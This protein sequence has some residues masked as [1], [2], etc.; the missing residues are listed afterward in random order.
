MVFVPIQG[1][2]FGTIRIC[3]RFFT[4]SRRTIT[5]LASP[6]PLLSSALELALPSSPP[7]VR[8]RSDGRVRPPSAHPRPGLP[9]RCRRQ[10]SRSLR[11]EVAASDSSSF[12][13]CKQPAEDPACPTRPSR[14]GQSFTSDA[15]RKHEA[16]SSP[17]PKQMMG[18]RKDLVSN[19]SVLVFRNLQQD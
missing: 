19:L 3:F 17:L 4:R 2:A 15:H 6:D 18:M 16:I 11:E 5:T 10:P 12:G 14:T 13:S 7:Y 8:S 9:S 1:V